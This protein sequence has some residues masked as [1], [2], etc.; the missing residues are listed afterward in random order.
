MGMGINKSPKWLPAGA[1]RAGSR[2]TDV[3]AHAPK[4]SGSTDD[5]V[6]PDCNNISDAR[7]DAYV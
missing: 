6:H 4:P 3:S 2:L 7:G 1:Y 5:E